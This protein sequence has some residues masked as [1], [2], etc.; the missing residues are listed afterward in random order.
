MALNGLQTNSATLKKS[1]SC[2]YKTACSKLNISQLTLVVSWILNHDGTYPL[3]PNSELSGCVPKRR[4]QE[5]ARIFL[6]IF[7]GKYL[8]KSCQ[9]KLHASADPEPLHSLYST[10][11]QW[12]HAANAMDKR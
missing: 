10:T 11:A 2:T 12:T 9:R 3:S 4:L 6:E 5:C 8:L 7:N 1:I